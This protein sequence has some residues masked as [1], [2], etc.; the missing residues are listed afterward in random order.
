MRTALKFAL[1]AGL[2]VA[3]LSPLTGADW[4]HWRGPAGTGVSAE[5]GLLAT[6]PKDGPKLLW[7]SKEAGN[8]YAGMAVVGGIV[9][10]MGAVKDDKAVK[11]DKKD[12]DYYVIKG[13]EFAIALDAS[14]KKLWSTKIGPV[15]DWNTNQWSWGPNAM[16]TVDGDHV[17]CLGSKGDLL[18]CKKADGAKVW[19]KN[20]PK[21]LGGLLVD[22]SGGFPKLGWG[23]SSS[24]VVDGDRL[25][26]TPGG[27]QGL[28]AALDKK[29][30]NLLWRSKAVTD[31]ALYVTPTVATIGGV[32]QYITMTQLGLT[33][34]S[35]E[36]GEL[37]W[38][39]KSEDELPDVL[40]PSPIVEGNLVYASYGLVGAGS[41]CV[42]L[43]IDVKGKKFTATVPY[44]SNSVLGNRQGGVVL[45][46][47]H[48]F[49][50]NEDRGLVCQDL[51]TGKSVW[52][53]ATQAIKVGSIVAG[54]G[55]LFVLAEDG[56]VAMIEASPK[57]YNLL[58]KFEL[59]EKAKK[60]KPS[61]KVWTHPSLSDGKLYLRDQELVFCYEVK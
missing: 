60:V 20:L 14:G 58:G 6:W 4:P 7:K 53:R 50:Y 61:A 48:L 32:K 11:L 3:S 59:P 41:G 42:G 38:Q 5:K 27:P 35:A 39:W 29:N 52:P 55:K 44:N 36:T 1:V 28:F 26:L 12:K 18:C 46:D 33:S 31:K 17:Y 30:G 9:Y 10:T 2:S 23:Y 34:V 57:K 49:G 13:D 8:G 54:D 24:P 45:I 43:K 37:L 19:S 51:E 16:P 21:D 40:C 47:K 22:T 15:L 56:K 25:I